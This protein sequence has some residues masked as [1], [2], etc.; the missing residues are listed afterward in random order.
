M[1]VF[2]LNPDGPDRMPVH[3][4]EP[5]M[6]IGAASDSDVRLT[7]NSLAEHHVRIEKK[8][9]GFYLINLHG[10]PD[11]LV[12]GVEI[13]FQRLN[14]GDQIDIAD[15]TA[16]VELEDHEK[17]QVREKY[18]SAQVRQNLNPASLST[19]SV[20]P[21]LFL[22]NRVGSLPLVSFIAALTVVGA[23][24]AFVLGLVALWIVRKRD[25]TRL[26][27]SMAK[28]SIGL[29]AL[30]MLVGMVAAFWCVQQVKENEL[31]DGAIGQEK[32][33]IRTVKNLVCAQR[34][35]HTIECFDADSDENAEYGTL[36]Q[37]QEVKP[38]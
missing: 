15:V 28:W 27:S 32:I 6:V 21:E 11:V 37:L 29:S 18:R 12:N 30:W 33:V 5:S 2:I 23:P 13:T 22:K 19:V 7:N 16:L 24:V 38:L 31:L 14:Q 35:F 8:P 20:E 9:D 17:N 34:Y 3:L 26:D 1:A 10:R 4:G 36:T 25:G